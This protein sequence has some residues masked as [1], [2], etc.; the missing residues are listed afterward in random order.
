MCYLAQQAAEKSIK[1]VL[2]LLQIDFSRS[3]NLVYLAG[4][5]PTGWVPVP[6][7]QELDDLTTWVA[8]ARYPGSWPEPDEDDARESIA[9]AVGILES[10][11]AD[12]A[13]HGVELD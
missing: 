7:T 9:L 3:H 11:H 10:I 5:L 4:L 12:L 6:N 1:A 13:L 8:P 2:V